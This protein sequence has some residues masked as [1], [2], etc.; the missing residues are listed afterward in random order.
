M[1]RLLGTIG[2]S[3]VSMIVGIAAL[4]AQSADFDRAALIEAARKEGKLVWYTGAPQ[5]LATA[6]LEAFGKK[7]PFIDTSEY[8]RQSAG[9]LQ[10]RMQ[11]EAAAG[12]KVADV[13]HSG[14]ITQ[15]KELES[16]FAKFETPEL[17]AYDAKYKNQG[18]WTA[19][20]LTTIDLAYNPNF[21]QAKDAP[22][23]WADLTSAKYRGKIGLQDATAG[24]MFVQ[25]FVLREKLGADY[26]AKIGANR[27]VIFTGSVPIVE[28]LLRGEVSVNANSVS[29]FDWQYAIRDGAPYKPVLPKEGVPV[30][31]N[32]IAVLADAPHP[33]AAR[34]FVDW[35]LSQEGQRVM[36]SDVGD[37]SPR[38][39]VDSPKGMP[40]L[41]EINTL[42]PSSLDALVAA[43]GEFAKQWAEFG[44]AK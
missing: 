35:V 42:V 37:Y 11:A 10:A 28:S 40:K 24:L 44:A 23:S 16:L 36:V 13:L 33:N 3:I 30:A 32:P 31:L 5:S 39:D 27:P 29:Y 26:W 2:A 43:K 17:A 41:A 7:Y 6:M 4:P 25:W 14:D 38:T 18:L 19:W 34:L 1:K 12:R 15:F 22:A 8:F 9:R 21:T 20:R